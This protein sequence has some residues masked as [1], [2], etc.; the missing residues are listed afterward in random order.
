MGEKY[1]ILSLI[2]EKYDI[3]LVNKWKIRYFVSK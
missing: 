2:S 3:L 1:D